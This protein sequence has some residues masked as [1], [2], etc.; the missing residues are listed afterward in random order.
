MMGIYLAAYATGKPTSAW[1][2]FVGLVAVAVLVGPLGLD[3]AVVMTAVL[4]P[5]WLWVLARGRAR[6]RPWFAIETL[7]LVFF[8]GLTIAAVVA[9]CRSGCRPR[10]ITRTT[11]GRRPGVLDDH[12][13]ASG[14]RCRLSSRVCQPMML[15]TISAVPLPDP[16]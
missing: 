3:A 2:A 11:T 15:T 14:S 6:D 4:G 5:L 1:L 10:H 12:G 16:R 9:D 13:R 8:G 7:G